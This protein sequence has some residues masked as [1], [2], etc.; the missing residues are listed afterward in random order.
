MLQSR[1]F[2]PVPLL[3]CIVSVFFFVL[4]HY[5]QGSLKLS[6]TVC[7]ATEAFKTKTVTTI[8]GHL[9]NRSLLFGNSPSQCCSSADSLSCPE[10]R[11]KR[12]RVPWLPSP[13]SLWMDLLQMHDKPMKIFELVY[14]GMKAINNTHYENKNQRHIHIIWQRRTISLT[15]AISTN[16]ATP[17]M[18][19]QE[20]GS[21]FVALVLPLS[22]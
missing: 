8:V 5:F 14:L 18:L 4:D 1:Y 19:L 17:R 2:Q 3:P 11:T 12:C 7:N 13:F 16:P 15:S 10:S 9:G 21:S 22:F 6:G 20:H